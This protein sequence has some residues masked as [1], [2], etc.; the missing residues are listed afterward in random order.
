MNPNY[1]YM[2]Q[3]DQDELLVSIRQHCTDYLEYVFNQLPTYLIRISNMTL[4]NRDEIRDD[5][6]MSFVQSLQIDLEEARMVKIWGSD[7]AFVKYCQAYIKG[8]LKYAIFSHRWGVREPKFREMSSSTDGEKPL[9]DG[10]G[11]DKLRKFCEKARDDYGCEFAWSDT[12]CINKESSSEMDEAIRSMYR[13][14]GD[15][16]VC[17]VHLAKSSSVEEF[18]TEPWFKRGWTLQELLAPSRLRFYG[19][20][21]TPIRPDEE[22]DDI[23]GK[24]LYCPWPN[25]KAS[26]F[27]LEAISEATHIAVRHLLDFDPK[28]VEVSEKMRWAS[29]RKTTRVEDVAYS[30]L[31]IFDISLPIAYGEGERAF[32]RFM[33][34]IAQ[35]STDPTLFAWTGKPSAYSN[36]LPSSPACYYG[37]RIPV[38]VPRILRSARHESHQ[39]AI[40]GDPGYTITKLGLRVKLLVVDVTAVSDIARCLLTPIDQALPQ[41]LT[42]LWQCSVI[43]PDHQYELGIVNY[44]KMD[45][46]HGELHAGHA[47]FC[48]LLRRLEVQLEDGDVEVRM[49]IP[50]D[51]LLTVHTTV[52][53]T[54]QLTTICLMHERVV[55]KAD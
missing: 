2:P 48:V 18:S 12:C 52:G 31:G 3:F 36:A 16:E 1:R 42:A 54:G 28:S 9:P 38:A 26:N 34:A 23:Y 47:Y 37:S 29:E 45:A 51:N 11:Y 55:V 4:L 19:M 53:Y 50:T 32:H 40:I 33:E 22:Q 41:R 6:Q 17:I 5:V 24:G 49:K 10:P 44:A 20:G 39:G 13:W 7:E 27:M 35:R 30:L 43:D 46:T 14:Y 15:A 21:W 25:D 8:F